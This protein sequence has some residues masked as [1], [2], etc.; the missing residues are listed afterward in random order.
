MKHIL[1]KT[2]G[3][4]S[5]RSLCFPYTNDEDE[6]NY[7]NR[8]LKENFWQALENCPIHLFSVNTGC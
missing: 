4:E 3:L 8:N 1:L 6:V 2:V 5:H 7:K